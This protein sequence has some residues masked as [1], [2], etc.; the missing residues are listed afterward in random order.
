M[1]TSHSLSP[2]SALPARKPCVTGCN[3]RAAVMRPKSW[4]SYAITP[5]MQPKSWYSYV[6]RNLKK[7][8]NQNPAKNLQPYFNAAMRPKLWFSYSTDDPQSTWFLI[9]GC[10]ARSILD[11]CAEQWLIRSTILAWQMNGHMVGQELC[12]GWRRLSTVSTYNH[13]NFGGRGKN[14]LA[15]CLEKISLHSLTA[16]ARSL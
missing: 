11:T 16:H 4:D 3:R 5:D 8:C 12:H 15:Q 1:Y 9:H 7:I 10:E 6:T 2:S 13:P 14:Q